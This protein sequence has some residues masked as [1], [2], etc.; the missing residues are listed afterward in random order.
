[1]KKRT[2]PRYPNKLLVAGVFTAIAGSLLLLWNFGY[3]PQ[4]G[5]L[6]PVGLIILGLVF[7]YLAWPRG[8]SDR[9]LIPGMI[10]TL[11]GIVILLMNT[12]LASQNIARIWPAFML[13]TG[14]SLV[15]YGFRR[16]GGARTAIV[17]PALFISCLSLVFLPFSL[18]HT[19]GGFAAFVRQWWPAIFVILGL[20]L[21]GSFF[22]MRR[23]SSKV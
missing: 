16:R 8:R 23:P 15:P 6:W 7:L 12:V 19:D 2:P 13:V 3:L 9:W 17:I 11:G 5:R 18:H 10:L 20:L 14:L 4:P 22:T 1:M 21:I